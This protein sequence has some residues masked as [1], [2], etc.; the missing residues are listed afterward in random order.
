VERETAVLCPQATSVD[1]DMTSSGHQDIVADRRNAVPQGKDD[2]FVLRDS[3]FVRR[4][5][6][7]E[8][9]DEAL[10]RKA[11]VP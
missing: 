10:G 4:D 11:V 3:V 9:I 8:T 2:I 1:A 7:R 6:F 5:A